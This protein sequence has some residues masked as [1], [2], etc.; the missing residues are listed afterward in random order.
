M[1]EISKKDRE[2]FLR[3]CRTALNRLGFSDGLMK[4]EVK[5]VKETYDK[6]I[7]TEIKRGNYGVV[8]DCRIIAIDKRMPSQKLRHAAPNVQW[9]LVDIAD[10]INLN[11]AFLK[12]NSFRRER[13]FNKT[14]NAQ[15]HFSECIEQ[16]HILSPRMLDNI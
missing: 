7:D 13:F 15:F 3:W 5:I 2:K 1:S 16:M 8:L 11:S 14:L 9:K 10:A 6:E 12:N 4:H